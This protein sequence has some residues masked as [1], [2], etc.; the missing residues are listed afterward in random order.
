MTSP[1][2]RAGTRTVRKRL[3]DGTIREYTYTRAPKPPR[4]PTDTAP[5]SLRALI[6]AYE[7][8]PEWAA[9]ADGSRA[10]RARAMRDL[11][12]VQHVRVAEWRRR[13]IL[14]IRDAIAHARG[15]AAANIFASTTSVMFG[16]AVDRGWIEHSPATRIRAL[17]GGTYPTWT[18][19]ELAV[20]LAGFVEP[21]R[22]AVILAVHTAQRRGDLCDLKWSDIRGEVI[23]LRQ[24]KTGRALALHIHP[25][26]ARELAA[27]R[28]DASGSTILTRDDGTPYSRTDITMMITRERRRLKMR[29]GLNL[30]GLRKLAATRLADAGCSTHE[31]AAWTG[32]TTLRE[33]ERYTVAA[34]Q[35]RLAAA[36]MARLAVVQPE[37]T[38]ANRKT[39]TK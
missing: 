25:D 12:K 11:A 4:A 19:A 3:A 13:D 21:A 17:P 9:L 27:W 22:R 24:E 29:D 8:S 16:W 6:A 33:V 26:L 1:D 34:N 18:E 37:T 31:I 10:I 23:R 39:N 20:A 15:P 30:H 32:H 2:P 14:L 36:G 35:E 5:D 7:R 38:A 28:R